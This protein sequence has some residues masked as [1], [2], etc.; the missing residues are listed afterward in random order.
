MWHQTLGPHAS[1]DVYVTDDPTM[2][3]RVLR[4]GEQ[5]WNLRRVNLDHDFSKAEIR[6][7][8]LQFVA[9]GNSLSKTSPFLHCTKSASIA[10]RI[11]QDVFENMQAAC[12]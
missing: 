1:P 10:V 12:I 11:W 3:I 8:V 7:L 5:P 2:C 9:D 6:A 4:K